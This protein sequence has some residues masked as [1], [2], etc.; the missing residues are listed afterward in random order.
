[1][2]WEP[3]GWA[4]LVPVWFA[5]GFL[6]AAGLIGRLMLAGRRPGRH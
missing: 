5:S 1:L 2:A 6:L 3:P 4:V